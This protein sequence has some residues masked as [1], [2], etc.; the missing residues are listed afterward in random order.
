MNQF[1]G[2]IFRVIERL[3]NLYLQILAAVFSAFGRALARIIA[4]LFTRLT[5]KPNRRAP[6]RRTSFERRRGNPRRR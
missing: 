4:D 3:L 1:L 6:P 5:R 2:F